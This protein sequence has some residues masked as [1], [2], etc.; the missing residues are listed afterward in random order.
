VE[1]QFATEPHP[2]SVTQKIS[3][4]FR[5][6]RSVWLII[7]FRILHDSMWCYLTELLDHILGL[8]L[9]ATLI[10]VVPAALGVFFLLLGLPFID[11]ADRLEPRHHRTK[12]TSVWIEYRL[13]VFVTLIFMGLM[14]VVPL[15]AMIYLFFI[16]SPVVESAK[17]STIFDG[18]TRVF[19][20]WGANLFV[21]S[22]ISAGSVVAWWI[23]IFSGTISIYEF[24]KKRKSKNAAGNTRPPIPPRSRFFG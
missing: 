17:F 2:R 23:G 6:T 14:F 7:D 1:V 12:S 9:F 10:L 3:V 11:R 13:M 8:I 5:V 20:S 18:L 19:V 15:G 16:L 22:L 21:G 24:F 4:Y